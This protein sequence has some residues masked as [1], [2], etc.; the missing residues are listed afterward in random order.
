MF[1]PR[2]SLPL[3]K[4][5]P[6][7]QQMVI[8]M[9]YNHFFIVILYHYLFSSGMFNSIS[10]LQFTPSLLNV[11][12]NETNVRLLGTPGSCILLTNTFPTVLGS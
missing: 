7:I 8:G 12:A 1:Q 5:S 6:P 11:I 3:S 2:V 4:V 10:L 9:Y